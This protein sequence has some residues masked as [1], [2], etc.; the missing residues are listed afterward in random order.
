MKNYVYVLALGALHPTAD[1]FA[2]QPY[3]QNSN[4]E[5]ISFT[6]S[7][8][9]NLRNNEVKVNG[10]NPSPDAQISQ[11][12]S[13]TQSTSS[14]LYNV[15][16][17]GGTAT[18]TVSTIDYSPTTRETVTDSSLYFT[19]EDDSISTDSSL[20]IPTSPWTEPETRSA[21][22]SKIA[23]IIVPGG[24]IKTCSFEESVQRIYVHLETEGRPLNANIELWQFE[25]APQTMS[26][27]L[28]DGCIRPFRA[29]VE[30]PG[31]C[32]SIAVRNTGNEDF[33]FHAGIEG[34][35]NEDHE[36]VQ[37]LLH[38]T[39]KRT[40][41]GG[42]VYPIS[43]PPSVRSVKIILHTDGRPLIARVELSKGP[44]NARQIIE[45][46]SEDG[47]ERPLN[48]IIETPGVGNAIRI[49]NIAGDE[50]PLTAYVE[51]YFSEDIFLDE[52]ILD[53]STSSSM[54]A[55]DVPWF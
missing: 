39:G 54:D 32:N 34:E 13:T 10:R 44:N 17:S 6:T 35:I 36:T 40:V 48:V 2:V 51:P 47:N 11:V 1:A 18:G 16:P 46:Y 15:E 20:D 38:E 31:S 8:L 19:P 55:I 49:L 9:E 26:V 25:D 50:F 12:A 4:T 14:I 21:M 27:Y 28:E 5:S 30:T 3:K 7:Y 52:P 45:I 23:P 33:P 43:L 37:T 22:F 24:S 42:A 41:Q 29:I 53:E